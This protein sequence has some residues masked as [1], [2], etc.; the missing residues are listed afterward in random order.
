MENLHDLD[1]GIG[2][3][4]TVGEQG[5][6]VVDLVLNESEHIGGCL[7]QVLLI[8]GHSGKRNLVWEPIDT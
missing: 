8:C 3:A 1:V 6:G 7:S 4:R 2:N 5:N